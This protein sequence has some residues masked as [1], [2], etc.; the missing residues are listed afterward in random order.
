MRPR[1]SIGWVVFALATP[2]FAEVPTH[3]LPESGDASRSL[4][5]HF[6]VD[7]VERLL[8]S[9]DP[10]ERLRGLERA[11]SLGTQDCISLLVHAVRDPLG[12]GRFDPRALLVIVRG[13]ANATQQGEVRQ[14][15]KENVL[16]A[17]ILQ[18]AAAGSAQEAEGTD[19]DARLGLARSIAALALATSPDPRA[20]AAL[21]LVARDAGPGQNAAAEA[22]AAFPPERVATVVTGP[23]PPSLLRLAAQIGDLRVLDAVRGTLSATDPASRAAA[24]DA[25]SELG[26]TRA[27]D[28]ARSATK[29]PDPRVREAAARALVHLGAPDRARAVE[30]LLADAATAKEGARLAEF[31]NDE[32]VTRTL[33]ARVAASS[34]PELRAAAVVALG[35]NTSD[36]AIRALVELVKSPLLEGDAA[37][38][39]ARSPNKA[40]MVAIEALLRAST[41]RRLG[42]RAY[43]V[44]A[45]TRG[46]ECASCR[47]VLESMAKS[48]DSKDRAVGLSVLV[49]LGQFRARDALADRDAGVRRAVA[50]AAQGDSREKTR[51]DLLLA[52]GKEPDAPTRRTMAGGLISSDPERL[53][54][55]TALVER[56][57]AAEEDAPIAAM[58]LAARGDPAN[59][60]RVSA[61]FASADPILR[62]HVAFGLGECR[63]PEATGELA[64]AYP[65]E[66]DPL[67]R[68]AIV[69]ALA[70][71]TQDEDAPARLA[72][73]RAARTLDPDGATRHAA[74][75]A[76]AGLPAAPRADARI[77]VAWVRLETV[78]G[79][80]PPPPPFGGAL[81]RS[82]GIAVP[83][84]FD[85]DGYAL[86]PLPSGSSRLLLAP[87]VRAY[88]ASAP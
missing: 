61:L 53:V 16:D 69:L 80:A 57:L 1:F 13:V 49:L 60:E 45:L 5:E 41:T 39:L 70:A 30:A 23:W 82:D 74:T 31:A 29:D 22:L 64:D 38:A 71:R 79:G 14:F 4:R 67:V 72:V 44:R 68:R 12:A 58:A 48:R 19:R 43:A 2:A 55:T 35:R 34:D 17:S 8:R 78:E 83:V 18:R 76:L 21:M 37:E 20:P 75:R 26:D 28:A 81:L 52:W 85:D 77:D 59:R 47:A 87:R 25:V 9:S 66:A 40:A 54:P 50:M 51:R 63:D 56:A 10:D 42:A 86:I 27:I 73:L 88:D 62:A 84:A 7:L 46:E 33:A 6:G 65:F 36:D 32:G 24:L 3:P 11:A 15:L